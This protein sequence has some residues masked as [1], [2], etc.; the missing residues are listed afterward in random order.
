MSLGKQKEKE[1][2]RWFQSVRK[3]QATNNVD[4]TKAKMGT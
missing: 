2:E 4:I 1:I 3:T